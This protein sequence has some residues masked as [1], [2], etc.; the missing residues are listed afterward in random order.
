MARDE[1]DLY[2]DVIQSQMRIHLSVPYP[3]RVI[4][5]CS[6]KATAVVTPRKV[7]YLVRV[8]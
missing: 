6:R 1:S 3:S 4:F 2:M 8:S 7:P 5:A